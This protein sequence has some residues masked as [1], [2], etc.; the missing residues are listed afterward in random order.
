MA[1][2]GISEKFVFTGIERRFD[3]MPSNGLGAGIR[4]FNGNVEPST[5]IGHGYAVC[6]DHVNLLGPSHGFQS[7]GEFDD[8]LLRHHFV[9]FD[10]QLVIGLSWI[11]T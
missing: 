11:R 4:S 7:G 3:D 1:G 5:E 8:L 6:L 2:P 9:D 10:H